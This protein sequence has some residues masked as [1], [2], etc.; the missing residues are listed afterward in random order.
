M[1]GLRGGRGEM[2]EG[3]RRG[4]SCEEKEFEQKTFL[5]FFSSL[6]LSGLLF[7]LL[8]SRGRLG[9]RRRGSVLNRT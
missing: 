1:V 6:S 3:R 9:G 8:A 4:E 7:L 2:A 5:S